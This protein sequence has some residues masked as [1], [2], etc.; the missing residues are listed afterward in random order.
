MFNLLFADFLI[1]LKND[2]DVKLTNLLLKE[3]KKEFK[4]VQLLKM[5][6]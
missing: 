5:K 6:F 3:K 1:E 4:N 2:S